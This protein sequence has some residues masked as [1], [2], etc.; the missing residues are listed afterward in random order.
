MDLSTT[1]LGLTLR[2]PL[3]VGSSTLTLDADKA[4]ACEA[5]GAGAVVLKSLFEEQIALDS[6]DLSSAVAGQGHWHSEA[7]EYMEAEIGMRYGT[8][9]YLRIIR[10]CKERVAIP[11]IASINCVDPEWW[12]DFAGQVEA[13][14]ADALEL[15]ISIMPTDI[16]VAAEDIEDRFAAIVRRARDAV[17]LPLAVKIGPYFTSPSQVIMRLADEGA[18]GFV[19]FNRFYRPTIDV[20]K[21]T[22][23][24]DS[25][26]SA[27]EEHSVPLRWISLLADRVRGDFAATTGIHTGEDAVRML[28][29]GARTVQVVSALYRNGVDHLQTMLE[30]IRD[31]AE[32]HRYETLDQFRGLMSQAQNP[33]QKLFGRLQYIKG[34][35]GIE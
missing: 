21:L 10:E 3:I 5:A 11:V 24:S 2:N 16:T 6:S 14:G 30:D 19:L 26:L 12:E 8:R 20:N 18:D 1:Y 33:D 35:V 4:A 9:Q 15:N 34:L 32:A 27:H 25:P 28:L 23:R 7:F 29:A 22:V 31:W 17:S 13:A